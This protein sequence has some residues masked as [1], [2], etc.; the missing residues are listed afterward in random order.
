MLQIETFRTE[1][2]EWR[3]VSVLPSSGHLAVRSS[4][5]L[6]VKFAD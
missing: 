5:K 3:T 1:S 2:P 6:L 4:Y